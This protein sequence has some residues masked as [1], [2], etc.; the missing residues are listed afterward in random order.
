MKKPQNLELKNIDLFY[1]AIN[2]TCR[3]ADADP[4]F[5]L[6]QQACMFSQVKADYIQGWRPSVDNYICYGLSYNDVF[7]RI[8]DGQVSLNGVYKDPDKI[9]YGVGIY[10]EDDI[11]RLTL[12]GEN[13]RLKEIIVEEPGD[14]E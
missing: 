1:S 9:V 6:A 14:D 3:Y 12:I 8:A 13:G 10:G 4:K 11:G 2:N 7:Y 5:N